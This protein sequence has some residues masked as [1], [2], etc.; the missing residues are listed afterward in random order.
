MTKKHFDALAR[1]FAQRNTSNEP[2]YNA[3][4]KLEQWSD[5][6]FAI[7]SVCKQFNPAFDQD[8]FDAEERF[9]EACISEAYN[10]LRK[11]RIDK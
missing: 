2:G 11:W 8:F 6:T 7:T 5:N 4:A 10:G 9:L 3:H 1:A